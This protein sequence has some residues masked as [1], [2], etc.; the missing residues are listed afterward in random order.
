M[1]VNYRY[2][3]E[4]LRYLLDNADA[5]IVVVHQDFVDLLAKV[6]GGLPKIKGVLVVTETPEAALPRF[7]Y[8]YEIVAETARPA[9]RTCRAAATT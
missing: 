8:D 5:E 7:A 9:R 2:R 4:E 3:E 6:I 1:N